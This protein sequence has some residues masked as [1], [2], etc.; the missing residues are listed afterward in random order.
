MSSQ[1]LIFTLETSTKKKY[2]ENL[3]RGE[4][5][6]ITK[7][8]RNFK[9]NSHLQSPQRTRPFMAI[10][11]TEA[12]FGL[13]TCSSLINFQ[14]HN[15]PTF[16][17]LLMFLLLFP[18]WRTSILCLPTNLILFSSNNNYVGREKVKHLGE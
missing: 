9:D 4:R 8:R 2:R 12:A 10:Y 15:L 3:G 18:K 16:P 14:K 17:I 11:T 6:G 1:F 5:K 7:V 13:K